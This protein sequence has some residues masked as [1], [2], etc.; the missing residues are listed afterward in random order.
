MALYGVARAMG[1]RGNG[2]VGGASRRTRTEGLG[3]TGTAQGADEPVNA[4]LDPRPGAPSD[5]LVIRPQRWIPFVVFPSLGLTG[6]LLA[7]LALV[8]L[9]HGQAAG[10]LFLLAAALAFYGIYMIIGGYLWPASTQFGSTRPW[11]RTTARREDLASL[12]IGRSAS[13]SGPPCSFVRKD[14]RIAF[15]TPVAVWGNDQLAALA[16]FLDVPLVDDRR[17]LS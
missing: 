12:R 13:R 5:R 15:S 4:N 17:R 2:V 8:I 11:E 14:G 1:S 10:V 3:S 16:R 6:V 7:G 9:V